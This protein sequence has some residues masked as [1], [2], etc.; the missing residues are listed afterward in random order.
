MEYVLPMPR[1]KKK[2]AVSFQRGNRE[3]KDDF[4][5]PKTKM[6]VSMKQVF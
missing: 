5:V 6:Y 3:R 1:K 4:T 2:M